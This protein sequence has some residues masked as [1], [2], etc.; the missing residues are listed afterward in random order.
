MQRRYPYLLSRT[1]ERCEFFF[2]E[3]D[4]LRSSFQ[5]LRTADASG[6][7]A[8][9]FVIPAQVESLR[10]RANVKSWAQRVVI[11]LAKAVGNHPQTA[12][13]MRADEKQAVSRDTASD[14]GGATGRCRLRPKVS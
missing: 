5:V 12:K 11:G 3:R 8:A 4:F 7:G 2:D 6:S 1:R 10:C 14:R 13:A 9:D